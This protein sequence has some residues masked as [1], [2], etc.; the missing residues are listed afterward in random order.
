LRENGG[1]YT[2]G[3]LWS[4]VAFA[5][6]GEGDK[7]ANLFNLLNPINH[8]RTPQEVSRYVVE[9]Y[10]VAADVYAAAPHVG[11]GGWTWYTGS[12][13]WM[14]RAGLENIL[15]LRVLAGVLHLDP[16]IPK[17]WPRFSISLKHGSARYNI[18]VENPNSVSS[19]IIAA[20]LDAANMAICPVK[21]VLAD[22]GAT[23]QVNVT[24]GKSI[25]SPIGI[26]Q[27][28]KGDTAPS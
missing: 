20:T 21:V 17:A 14:Q 2:H 26:R 23:H 7:A 25:H 3:A 18:T 22:D 5:M 6:L 8:A 28:A 12:A 13:G 16:C 15:G 4:V 1:Q 24:L 27:G 10:V 11:R 9:P 19:G